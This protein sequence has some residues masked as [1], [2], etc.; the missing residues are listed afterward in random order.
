MTCAEPGYDVVRTR[1]DLE[2]LGKVVRKTFNRIKEV[3]GEKAEVFVF[4]AAPAACC[5]EFGRV[6]QPKAHRPMEIYDQVKD[7]WFVH[8]LRIE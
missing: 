4:P 6:W 7:L 2:E 1:E 8:R 3:H 5:I